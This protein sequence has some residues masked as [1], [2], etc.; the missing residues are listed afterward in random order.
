MS[1]ATAMD[2]AKRAKQ[3][4][5]VGVGLFVLGGIGEI[6]DHALFHGLP[7]WGQTLLFD[8][9]VA[10]VLVA[11]LAPLVFGIVLPLTE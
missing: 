5:L 10:G 2:H 6:A 3:G 1:Q 8:A 9:E 7:G 4:F 11:L